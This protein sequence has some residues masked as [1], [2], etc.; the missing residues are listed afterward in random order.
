LS[1]VIPSLGRIV[2]RQWRDCWPSTGWVIVDPARQVGA[3][4]RSESELPIADHPIGPIA[5]EIAHHPITRSPI[6]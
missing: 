1:V 5:D 4:A 6:Q 2:G 3:S